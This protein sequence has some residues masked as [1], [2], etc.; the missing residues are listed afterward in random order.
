VPFVLEADLRHLSRLCLVALFPLLALPATSGTGISVL[1][2]G[3]DPMGAKDS[4]SAI[5]NAAN[6]ADNANTT[7]YVPDGLYRVT[8]PI[9]LQSSV[10]ME[11]SASIKA[12]AAMT[13]VLRV[14]SEKMATQ[15]TFEGGIVDAN[16]LAQEGI[17]F[18]QYGHV[19]VKDIAVKNALTNAFHFGDTAFSAGNYEAIVTGISS[20]RDNG[21]LQ[22][23]SVG[24]Y[25]DRNAADGNFS[26][27]TFT[28][29]DIGVKVLTGGN[30]FTDLHVWTPQSTGKMSVG[31]DDN[32]IGNFW[33]GCEADTVS[34][35]G[36]R[37]RQYNT[38]VQGCRFYVNKDY[39]EDATATA[40]LF[41]H[42]SPAATVVD[43]LFSGGD[44][45][46]RWAADIAGATSAIAVAGNHSV[47]V[48]SVLTVGSTMTGNLALHGTLSSGSVYADSLSAVAAAA[49]SSKNTS[50]S[51]SLG[52]NWY[53]NSTSAANGYNW[54]LAPSQT[55]TGTPTT[56]D[57]FLFTKGTLPPGV[58]PRLVFGSASATTT[59][60]QI[61]SLQQVLQSSYKTGSSSAYDNWGIQSVLGTGSAPSSTLQL[62]HWG[63]S[64]SASVAIPALTLHGET[65][66]S[67]PRLT[68][69]P[70]GMCPITSANCQE[71]SLWNPG[72]GITITQWTFTLQTAPVAC[73]SYGTVS[74]LQGSQ[75]L[76]SV[77]L[78]SRQVNYVGGRNLS[79]P[80]ESENGSLSI[81]VTSPAS[82]CQTSPA[83]VSTTLEYIMQ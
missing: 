29:T 68:W 30:F 17:F 40:I 70:Y 50:A 39:G 32:G 53:N 15:M 44:G 23:G 80:A 33:K 69:T 37:A 81:V 9:E 13:A 3:A 64:G 19:R 56:A 38:V 24:L 36:L 61:P 31:F 21:V 46:H 8:S 28:G 67:L 12:N 83:G 7:L 6:A 16:N 20:S 41:D 1:T 54:T 2:Y 10:H 52:S 74:L 51:L 62:T 71:S 34:S 63:S 4:T 26:Q 14:G 49:T 45:T 58:T 48:A 18:R 75:V 79:I 65:I 47:N 76:A 72:R 25:V 22:D 57:L 27:C 77:K 43:T 66:N 73:A 59:V 35:Y 82:G 55:S 78:G 5:Q 60:P 42:A 11:P